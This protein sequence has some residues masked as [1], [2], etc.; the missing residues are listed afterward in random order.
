MIVVMGKLYTII[1]NYIMCGGFITFINM[2]IS[3]ARLSSLPLAAEEEAVG[4]L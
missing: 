2:A 1:D 3:S 4:R